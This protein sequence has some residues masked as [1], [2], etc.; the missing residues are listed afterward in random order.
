[1]YRNVYGRILYS[2]EHFANFFRELLANI[3]AGQGTSAASE[4]LVRPTG[5]NLAL[6]KKS[7]FLVTVSLVG[8]QYIQTVSKEKY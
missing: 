3:A 7:S 1:M 5:R 8:G 4:L 2:C 6:M